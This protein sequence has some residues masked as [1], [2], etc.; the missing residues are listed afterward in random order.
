MSFIMCLYTQQKGCDPGGQEEA[1]Q[2]CCLL[3]SM[4][5]VN[6]LMIAPANF[7]YIVLFR[8]IAP[9]KS[10]GM[11]KSS[12]KIPSR[13]THQTEASSDPGLLPMPR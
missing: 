6:S 4:D 7:R 5:P 8:K 11:E 9:F 13:L 10:M 3:C 1:L 12:F 2:Q